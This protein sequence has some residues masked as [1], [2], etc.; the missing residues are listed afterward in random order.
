MKSEF[1]SGV[2]TE[3]PIDDINVEMQMRVLLLGH[4][5]AEPKGRMNTAFHDGH[6]PPLRI[7]NRRAKRATAGRS[8]I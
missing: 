8:G 2:L 4:S 6:S 5:S 3:D 1:S 7:A